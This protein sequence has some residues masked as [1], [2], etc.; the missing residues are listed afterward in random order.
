MP[1]C[2]LSA[3]EQQKRKLLASKTRSEIRSHMKIEEEDETSLFV[4]YRDY[5]IQITFGDF[6]PLMVLRLAKSLLQTDT[7]EQHQMTN[8][9]NLH[10]VFGCHAVNEEAGCYSYRTTLWLDTA[11]SAR[12]FFEILDRCVDEADRGYLN[13]AVNSCKIPD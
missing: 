7:A 11:L 12:R 5:F 2:D 3:A 6:H 9:L 8:D 13:L 10:S 1:H 4:V